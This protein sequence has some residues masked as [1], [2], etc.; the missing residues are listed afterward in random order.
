MEV[1]N[2]EQTTS[3]LSLI[4]FSFMD[5]LISEASKVPHLSHERLPVIADYDRAEYL[6]EKAFPV[7]IGNLI[8]CK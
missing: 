4:L 2:P 7:R 5:P 8:Y 1:P 6:R 3:V